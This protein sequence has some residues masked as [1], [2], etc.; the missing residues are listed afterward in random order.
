H[1]IAESLY[2]S[3]KLK[4]KDYALY[5]SK[6]EYFPDD[7]NIEAL[8]DYLKYRIFQDLKRGWRYT[9]PNLEQVALLDIDYKNLNRLSELD[10][11]FENLE[12]LRDISKESRKEFL[13]NILDYFRTNFALDHKFFKD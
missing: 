12:L 8:K 5:P 6:D 9:L 7:R 3:L 1:E 2:Q 4:E 10:A 13:K 11:R